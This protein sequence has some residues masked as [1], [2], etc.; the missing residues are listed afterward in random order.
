MG[1]YKS[2]DNQVAFSKKQRFSYKY[3]QNPGPGG[4]DP[5]EKKSGVVYTMATSRRD[6]L[7]NKNQAPGP[8]TYNNI[9]ED[10]TRSRTPNVKFS[11][12]QKDFYVKVT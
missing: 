2:A 10:T 9:N 4:Y 7:S 5:K 6:S 8:G 11:Q 12:S 3:D 1:V